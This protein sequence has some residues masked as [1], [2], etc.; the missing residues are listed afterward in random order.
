MWKILKEAFQGIKDDQYTSGL[1]EKI[2]HMFPEQDEAFQV[3][4]AC[5]SGLMARIAF[6]DMSI[7]D[8]ERETIASSLIKWMD[9]KKSDAEAVAKLCTEEVKNLAGIENHLYCLPL[10]DTLSNEE[11][12]E[13]VEVLFSIAASDGNVENNESEEIR[14]VT[15]ALL[16]EHKHFISARSTVLEY[17]GALKK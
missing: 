1:H 2:V 17:L 6:A 11:K 14:N 13:I 10:R 3:K 8:E 4:M 5:L 9:L 16:L 7:S 15:T 12:Y